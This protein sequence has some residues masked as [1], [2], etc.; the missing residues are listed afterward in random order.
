M[1]PDR[2]HVSHYTSCKYSNYIWVSKACCSS[3]CVIP[4]WYFNYNASIG[5]SILLR[6]YR[7]SEVIKLLAV[8]KFT[9]TWGD[10]G[11]YLPVNV[12][13]GTEFDIFNSGIV[14]SYMLYAEWCRICSLVRH[15]KI[16][17]GHPL[18]FFLNP[19][20]QFGVD[21]FLQFSMRC[22]FKY[23]DD[24]NHGRPSAASVDYIGFSRMLIMMVPNNRLYK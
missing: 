21:S 20:I 16:L 19:H 24:D 13:N 2:T 9:Y 23:D 11:F 8:V 10:R 1:F 7:G 4:V 17:T 14:I 22:F 3:V 15:S 5:L 18:P 6:L 12:S